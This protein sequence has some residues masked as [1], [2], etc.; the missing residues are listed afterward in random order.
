MSSIHLKEAGISAVK[1]AL[2]AIPYAGQVLNEI[3]FDYRGRIKQER[4]NSFAL[5]LIEYF[6]SATEVKIESLK[7]EGF[8]DL[9]EAVI[10]RVTQTSSG[11]K[12]QR[13]RDI[14]VNYIE[15]PVFLGDHSETYL[16]LI[17]QLNETEI[18][19]LKYHEVF[20]GVYL[21]RGIEL[22]DLE[23][24]LVDKREQLRREKDLEEKGLANDLPLIEAEVEKVDTEMRVEKNKM[25]QLAM[26][27]TP[28]FYNLSENDF[29]YF[30][31]TLYN[32]ALLTDHGVGAIGTHP[33]E[34]MGITEFGK[35]FLQFLTESK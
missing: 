16:D 23:V 8:S 3:L 35:K 27:R 15:Q 14:L 22:Q 34:L 12:H 6:S 5:L 2:S 29:F 9:F 17:T 25:E 30:K 4:I 11:Q 20:D 18:H 24:E 21:K 26:Y 31:Q 13:F 19:I 1:S 33:F 10:K 28:G 7:T 32:K